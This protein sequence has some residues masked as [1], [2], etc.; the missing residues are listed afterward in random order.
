VNVP[1]TFGNLGTAT[2][3]SL[4]YTLTLPPGLSGV[5]CSGATCSYNSSTGV[6]TVTGLPDS[7]AS[8]QTVNFTLNYT[9]PASGTVQVTSTVATR[10][11]TDSNPNNNSAS[12]RTAISA[13]NLFDPPSGRKTV[14]A[15]GLPIL[16]WRMVWINDGNQDAL[17][18]RVVDAIPAGTTYDPGSLRCEARG[19]STVALCT[20]EPGQN[21][22]V[23]EGSIAADPAAQDEATAQNEVVIVFNSQIQQG[24][25]YAGNIGEAYWDENGD[26]SVDDDIANG[27]KPVMTNNGQ[28]VQ[29][30]I[31]IPTLSQWSLI[32]LSLLLGWLAMG[33]LERRR[34]SG[35]VG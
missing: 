18:V 34:S 25:T 22:I 32:L 23:Y 24:V 4:S 2:A 9:A 30:P 28:P 11:S 3:T 15:A 29:P 12:G 14:N 27:Q 6:V 10:S 16:E 7:L 20:Y 8:G 1:V 21:R 19:A 17:R 26:G 33:Y 35:F 13:P 31:D 5:S